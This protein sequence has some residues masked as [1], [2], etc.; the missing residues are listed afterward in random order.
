MLLITCVDCRY[1]N[2]IHKYMRTHFPG[3]IYDQ[4]S[5]AGAVLAA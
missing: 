2:A 4:V 3:V 1:P 5:M